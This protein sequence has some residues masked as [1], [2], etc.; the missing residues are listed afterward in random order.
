MSDNTTILNYET[1]KKNC[2][3]NS[4]ASKCWHDNNHPESNI[5]PLVRLGAL[6]EGLVRDEEIVDFK[7]AGQNKRWISEQPCM[8]QI[9]TPDNHY[10]STEYCS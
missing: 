1:Q 8:I 3:E 2:N 4:K 9:K 6:Q 5:P 10:L 7:S